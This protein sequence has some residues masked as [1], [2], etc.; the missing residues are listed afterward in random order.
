MNGTHFFTC[1][2]YLTF[3]TILKGKDCHPP[4][5]W[6]GN[7]LSGGRYVAQPDKGIQSQG[8]LLPVVLSWVPY[9]LQ[10]Y[11]SSGWISRKNCERLWGEK[12]KKKK[13][14][15]MSCPVHLSELSSPFPVSELFY[16]SVNCRK[17]IMITKWFLS[18]E[19]QI[20]CGWWNATDHCPED[21][22]FFVSICKTTSSFLICLYI[23]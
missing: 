21:R 5:Y 13:D 23:Y 1:A 15:S 7:R 16:S 2:S 20:R 17:I 18:T 9:A 4:Y 12:Q 3:V 19:L 22:W 6:K 8:C 11:A 10:R 14:Y